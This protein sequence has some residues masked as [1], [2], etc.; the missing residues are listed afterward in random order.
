MFTIRT[1][2]QSFQPVELSPEVL[3]TLCNQEMTVT[4]DEL[5]VSDINAVS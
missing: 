4:I 5:H 1:L 3:D 2:G